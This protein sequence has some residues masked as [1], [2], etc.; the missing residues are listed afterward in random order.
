VPRDSFAYLLSIKPTPGMASCTPAQI[1][2]R[3]GKPLRTQVVAGTPQHPEELLLFY[4]F[5]QNAPQRNIRPFL[6]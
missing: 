3:L 1:I 5:S 4:N 2:R 6:R